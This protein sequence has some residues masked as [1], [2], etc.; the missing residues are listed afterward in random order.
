M[1]KAFSLQPNELQQSQALESERLELLAQLGSMQLENERIRARL[2]QV[3]ELQR[4]L[5]QG[6][7]QRLGIERYNVAHIDRTN[8]IVDLPDE[9][10]SLPTTDENAHPNGVAKL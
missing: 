5:V 8:V 4:K 10:A 9:Q 2:P 3:I 7:V 6:A 1:Q